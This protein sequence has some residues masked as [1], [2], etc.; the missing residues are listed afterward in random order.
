[1]GLAAGE[2]ASP[3]QN[4]GRDV[5]QEIAI[6]KESFMKASKMSNIFNVFEIKSQKSEKKSEFAG[7]WI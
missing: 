2:D 1:M 6:F 5:R 7:R 4:S 3:V